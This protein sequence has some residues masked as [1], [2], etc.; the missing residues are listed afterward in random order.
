MQV[1]CHKINFALDSDPNLYCLT[2]MGGEQAMQ[3]Y[4][5]IFAGSGLIS[6]EFIIAMRKMPLH[7]HRQSCRM[8]AVK[9]FN[10]H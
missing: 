9:K 1:M 6:V 10:V 3:K 8:L 4:A 5:A 7:G 2:C